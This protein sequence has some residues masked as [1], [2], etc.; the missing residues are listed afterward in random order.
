MSM[1]D[2]AL[3]LCVTVPAQQWDFITRRQRYLEAVVVQIL[4][5][6]T[7]VREWFTAG[8][9]AAFG[10]QALPASKSGI[11]R[12]A[13]ARGWLR[14]QAWASGRRCYEYHIINLPGRAFDDLICRIVTAPVEIEDRQP[15]PEIPCPPPATAEGAK[16]APPWLLP[17]VRIIK[18]QA[19]GTI[20]EAVESLRDSLPSGVGC[21]S[22]DE[23]ESVLR[24]HGFAVLD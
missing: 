14:R 2:D 22:I 13:T 19:F 17:L 12:M 21:P 9:L 3:P 4:R 11:A 6:N 8:E 5:E 7:G 16:P 1:N 10:L 20:S 18:G 24:S 23:A 15:V